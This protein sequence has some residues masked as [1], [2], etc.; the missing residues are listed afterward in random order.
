M[1]ALPSLGRLRSGERGG[2]DLLRNQP[3]L[4]GALHFMSLNM[5]IATTVINARVVRRAIWTS[6]PAGFR[7]CHSRSSV[8]PAAAYHQQS[9]MAPKIIYFPV[10]GRAEVMK[11]A[12]VAS[13]DDFELE[14]VNFQ[15][16]K[17]HPELYPFGQCPRLV[18]GD[19]D[20]VQSNA[21]IRYLGRKYGLYG[22]SEKET[23]AVDEILEGVE[24]LRCKYLTLIYQDQLATKDAYWTSHG[25]PASVDSRNGG[26]HLL[27]FSRL[28]ARNKEAGGGGGKAFVGSGLTLADL[29]VYDIVDLHVRIFGDQM[30][31]AYPD[32]LSFH[33]A[34]SELPGIKD[35]LASPRRLAA[36]N[37]N[38]LG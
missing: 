31:A 14:Q 30:Q 2:R 16:M 19:N 22:K 26:A 11:L 32:L 27:Y 35:Y 6:A 21:I 20:M 23:I 4:L 18:D 5:R 29:A 1:L 28:L 3:N 37:G 33:S 9:T 38:N 15:D 17:A 13:G 34:I 10:R 12:I 7:H 25:D 8:Q 24:S 36:V